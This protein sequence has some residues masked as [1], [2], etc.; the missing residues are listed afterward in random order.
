MN[1]KDVKYKKEEKDS[2]F[3]T[4]NKRVNDYFVSNEISKKTNAFGVFK[5]LLF[6]AAFAVTYTLILRANGSSALLLT[7]FALLG[8]IQICLVLNLGHEG[9]HS[10]FSNNRI[11][12]HLFTYTFDLLGSSGYL[13]KMRHVYSHHPNPMVPEH[14]V[15]I[16]QTGMLTFQ[17]LENPP[18][19]YKY[20]KIYAPLLYCFYSLN[21]ILRRDWTDFFSYKIG[22]KEV[23]HSTA[24]VISFIVSKIIYFSYALV[25]PLIF[26]GC[27]WSIV[28][29]G[30]FF[31]HVVASLAAATALFPAHLYE[32][33]I[34]PEPDK[35]GDMSSTW[36]EHQMS[37]TMDFGTKWP[38]ASFFFGGIN[39]H[40][41]HHLFPAMA[42]VHFPEVRKI[43]V[44]TAAEYNIPYRHMPTLS[45]AMVSHWK[46]LRKN[47]VA[48][49]NEIF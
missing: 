31:M 44:E 2:F 15:D 24:Q 12:N 49:L 25:L 9:V 23:K 4:V 34:F 10:S 41:V 47:G 19:S 16:Q 17:P 39:Y 1:A 42:H 29:L 40:A 20:Q 33:S 45:Q 30:F 26:S 37:V 11:I 18:P 5:A 38:F 6:L 35:N 46:L 32:E 48:Q 8:F 14:D 28:L 27:S 36:A 43:M 3:Y 21:A 13:W 22:S 7:C